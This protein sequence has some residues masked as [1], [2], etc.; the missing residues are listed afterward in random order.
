[1]AGI[2]MAQNQVVGVVKTLAGEPLPGAHVH[3]SQY[4]QSTNPIGN[5]EFNH[6]PNGQ[7]RLVAS[8]V[9]YVTKDTII[10]VFNDVNLAIV[11]K[12]DQQ[13]LNELVV[14]TNAQKQ[15]ENLSR[16]NQKQIID[17]YSGSFALSLAEVPGVNASQIGAGQSKPIIRGLSANRV[18]VTENG[19]KQEGQQWGAD[20]GLEIDAFN[21]E[22]VSIIKGVGTIAYGSDAM[23]GVISIDNSS[24][25][26]DSLT[27][28][29]NLLAKS[30]N[31][32]YG[33]NLNLKQK[34]K[35]VYYKLN[36]TFLDYADYKVP[37]NQIQYLNYRI[38]IFNERLKNTAGTERDFAGQV[39]FVNDKW[40]SFI[41]V[42]NN[43]VK[44]GFFPGAHGVPNIN[45]VQPDGNI[46][47]IEFPYQSVNHLK[48][49]SN[50]TYKTADGEF[51]LNIAFQNNHRQ[52]WSAFHTHYNNQT[53]PAHNPDLEL[54]F[55]LTTL[56]NQFAYKHRW[57]AH[58]QSKVGV[59]YQYQINKS[60]GYSYLLPNFDK[61]AIG[62][63][64][65]HE[66]QFNSKFKADVGLRFDYANLNIASY[67]D[68][69][70]YDYLVGNGKSDALANYY[71]LRTPKIDKNFTAYNFALG[72]NYVLS[73]KWNLNFTAA[74]NFRFPTAIELGSNGI[75]HGA[76]RHEQGDA[77]LNPEKGWAFDAV[78]DYNTPTFALSVSPYLYY[79]TNYIYLK[80]SGQFSILPH[81]GQIYSYTQ[82]EAILTGFEL[83]ATQN[84]GAHFSA[85][86]IF[87]YL[88]N[89]QITA[90][91][92]S[93]YALP[94]TPANS[95]FAK[96]SY[97][98]NDYRFFKKS[99]LYLSGKYAFAQNNI[100][101]NEEIT[102]QY[103]TF[104]AGI[105]TS[106]QLKKFKANAQL[107]ATN[108]FNEKY[109][110]H[111]SYYRAI[112]IPELG[113]NIQLIV[114]IPF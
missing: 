82:S 36:A 89:Q 72:F 53:P 93:D 21:A 75:H 46:R 23:G 73:Q 49:I 47:N 26:A 109:F 105:G 3:L 103:Y 91:R 56:D 20:H 63:F 37:T 96:I 70:L 1:M 42:S 39:G 30:V 79:F 2:G 41:Q 111:S 43:Y 66:Y 38:P 87:E 50:S 40:H 4:S 98:F 31:D 55:K 113:R 69:T 58:Q 80:P 67:Y 52:E 22:K 10:D 106:I 112:Q 16:V 45:A 60:A 88:K 81:G 77:N 86:A 99:K 15:I 8:F 35:A 95:V 74:S 97:A 18:A 104:G 27:G 83:K 114:T 7:Y 24:I 65:T 28:T 17:N 108:I 107:T 64:A 9:G 25:P 101:Q 48:V 68:K 71:A 32:G 5:F 11:L 19:I 54:D 57:S 33:V 100:A 90:N 34:N 85:E 110:N 59:Q 13:F 6:I 12:E 78:I 44:A 14:V 102:P 51:S 61:K 29:V 62:V 76:F 84:F 92:N 94:F